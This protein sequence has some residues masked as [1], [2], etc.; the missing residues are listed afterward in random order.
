[1]ATPK[2]IV[3]L[4]Q[5]FLVNRGERGRLIKA[6]TTTSMV[7]KMASAWGI[8]VVETSVGFR[9]QCPEILKG[10]AL[11]AVEE[12]GSIGFPNH[13]PERDGLMAGMMMLE[14]LAMTRQTIPRLLARLEKEYGPH[15]YARVDLH[16][17]VERRAA[18]MA[19]CQAHPPASLLRS[20]LE[21]VRTFDG[22]KYVARDTSWLMLRGSGTEPV[23]RIYAEGRSPRAA[24]QL[25][26]LGRRLAKQ[27]AE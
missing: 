17:P 9:H 22:V 2:I 23:L 21:A 1:M 7:D 25:L 3:L 13:L 12:S 16:F 18:L 19:Y 8:E 14:L 10:G 11:L 26:A 6:L 5:H 27:G 24:H 15:H 20:P 4:L